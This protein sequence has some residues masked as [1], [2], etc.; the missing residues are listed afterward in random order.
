MC[1][2]E[3]SRTFRYALKKQAE[4]LKRGAG[5]SCRQLIRSRGGVHSREAA[6]SGSLLESLPEWVRV[7]KLEVSSWGRGNWLSPG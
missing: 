2:S 3:S 4:R 7:Q 5:L 1:I 6:G